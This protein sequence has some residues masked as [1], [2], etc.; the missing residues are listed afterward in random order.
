MESVVEIVN[1]NKYF[2]KNHVLKNINLSVFRGDVIVI[3]GPSGAGK[4]T[5]LRCINRLEHFENGTIKVLGRE[6]KTH[7]DLMYIRRNT[8][9]VFQHFNLF[10]HLT[11]LDNLIIAPVHVKKLPRSEATEKAK[12]LLNRVGLGHKLTSYPDQLSGGE[13][14]RVA[15]ARA[16][17]MDPQIMMF[18]EP[19]SALDPEMIK[20]VLDVMI[21]LAKA[22]MTMIVVTHEMG[23]AREVSNRIAFM[24]K[25]E[26][27]EIT[28]KERFFTNPQSERARE[29]LSKIL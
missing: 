26:M 29:F 24:D 3:C 19:T 8:G 7:S 27:V 12:S 22:G 18:D 21:D 13:K 28:S 25:G 1:L 10:P 20:E 14:Q 17:A 5:L 15:I 2:G 16:L 4:S 11:V 9:M 23:F 6:I